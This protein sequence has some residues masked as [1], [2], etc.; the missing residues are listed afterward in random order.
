MSKQ[1]TKKKYHTSCR[2]IRHSLVT[3][4][5][6]ALGKGG[7]TTMGKQEWETRPS[8]APLFTD[9]EHASGACRSCT[10]GWAHPHNYPADRS[11][12]NQEIKSGYQSVMITK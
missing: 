2:I 11:A 8:N 12:P 7:K 6:L 1:T 5:T 10:Q 4:Y 3:H 9:E